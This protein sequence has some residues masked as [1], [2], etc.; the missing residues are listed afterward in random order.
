[1][2]VVRMMIVIISLFDQPWAIG[3]L[4]GRD[5]FTSTTATFHIPPSLRR[6]NLSILVKGRRHPL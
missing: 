1:M 2:M 6:Y 5:V 3:V 4:M